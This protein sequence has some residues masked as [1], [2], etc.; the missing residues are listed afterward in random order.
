MVSCQG[1]SCCVAMTTCHSGC[2]ARH[3]TSS[4]F[5]IHTH[6]HMHAY[7]YIF[8]SLMNVWKPGLPATGLETSLRTQLDTNRHNDK[9][10]C[11]FCFLFPLNT[12]RFVCGSLLCVCVCGW[13]GDQKYVYN[14]QTS[15]YLTQHQTVPKWIR[16]GKPCALYV[17]GDILYRCMLGWGWIVALYKISGMMISSH[18]Q[19]W[20][21]FNHECDLSQNLL[22]VFWGICAS[23]LITETGNERRGQR[24]LVIRKSGTLTLNV[25]THY[26]PCYTNFNQ[27][28]LVA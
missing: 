3:S 11:L 17:W 13:G 26:A 5:T 22:Q 23:V 10:S 2:S 28:L 25:Q 27:V 14:P 8:T 6:T 21:P 4:S 1:Q 15:W 9:A 24:S 12:R 19:L 18:S 7:T 16:R 20:F